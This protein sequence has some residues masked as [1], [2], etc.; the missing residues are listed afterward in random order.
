MKK[1]V[2]ASRSPYR[3]ELLQKLKIAFLTCSSDIDESAKP[4]ESGEQL[5]IRLA[6]AKAEA[7]AKKHP[8]HLIIGSDQVAVHRHKQLC[9]PG[10]REN[11]LRQ[12][13]E[14]SGHAVKFHTG[15]CV[16]DSASGKYLTAL[17]TCTVYFKKLSVNQ[18][19]HYID[20]EQPYDCAG[21]FKSEGLGI[22]LF[23]KIDS[24]DPNA[25]IG[26]PLIKLVNLLEQ[27]DYPVL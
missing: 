15:L 21:S 22:A 25:L 12:L 3:S 2:L 9:K 27:F 17:D 16:L 26:L 8:N 23:E 13:T 7:V 4:S 24:E 5:A 10:N 18:I 19:Q 11:A 6:I 14:Q 1:L 20:R